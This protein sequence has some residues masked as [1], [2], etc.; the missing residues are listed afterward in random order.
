MNRGVDRQAVYLTDADRREFLRLLGEAHERYEVETLAYCLMDNHFHLLCREISGGLSEAMQ[1]LG[2]VYTRH[3]NARVGRDGPLFRGRFHSIPVETDPYLLWVS[4]Y[5]HRNPLDL[6]G[7]RNI[8]RYRWSSYPAYLGKRRPDEFL[9]TNLLLEY[10]DQDPTRLA[11]FTGG[12]TEP[13]PWNAIP[14]VATRTEAT[15]AE[16]VEIVECALALDDLRHGNGDDP[17]NQWLTRTV[18]VLLAHWLPAGGL[19]TSLV[20]LLDLG[21][22]RTAYEALRRAEQRRSRIASVDRSLT[23]VQRYVCLDAL[24]AAV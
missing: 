17:P 21:S 16:L 14:R 22:G 2:S 19:R 13:G 10:F 23:L 18:L 9:N 12:V 15:V 5:I 20:E 11:R 8:A 4:R 7:V 6:P 3:T 24:A 1:H